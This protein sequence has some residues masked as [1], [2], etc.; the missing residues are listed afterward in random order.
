[1]V[2]RW[3]PISPLMETPKSPTTGRPRLGKVKHKISLTKKATEVLK[4]KAF[5]LGVDRSDIMETL[6]REKY[7]EAFAPKKPAAKAA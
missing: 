5:T 6:L 2:P 7:P 1:M 3:S 4:K